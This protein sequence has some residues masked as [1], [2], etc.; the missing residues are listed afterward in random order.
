[1]SYSITN[2]N[3]MN[4][5]TS[6]LLFFLFMIFLASCRKDQAQPL[7]NLIIFLADDLGYNDISCYREATPDQPE[8]APTSMTPNI[9]QLAEEGM[10]FTGFYAGA[11]VCSPSRSALITGR[12]A[13][14]V[15]IYN[16]IPANCPMHL[17]DEEI[18]IAEM[19]KQ[20]G[21]RT[22]HFGKW[23]LTSPGMGQPLPRDQG[24][25]YSFFTY[26][27]A[28]PSH[29]DPVNFHRNGR[30]VGPLEGYACQL[31][32]DE[33]LGWLDS[34]RTG[35]K[36][37]FMNV[38]FNEPH[39]KLAAP[40][41]LTARHDYNQE[42]YGTIENM[43]LAIGR[44]MTFLK[45][46]GLDKNTILIFTSDNGSQ[47][48][49][50]NYPFRGS[51]AFNYEGG[52]RVPFVIKWA[53]EIPAGEVSGVTGSLTDVFPS[54]ASITG[55]ALPGDREFDGIDLSP[56]FR[57]EVDDYQREDPVF[58]YR[59]F[60]DP[61]CMLR[62][63]NWSLL[64]YDKLIPYSLNLNT[65]DLAKIKPEPGEP[66][67]SE[68]GFKENHMEIILEQEPRIFELYNLE[69]DPEQKNNLAGQYP[70]RV[71]EMKAR[72]L[73]LRKEMIEE[74]GDWYD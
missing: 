10:R 39:V 73:E 22:G 66:Q 41:E 46:N 3:I 51:K 23:H 16:W 52:V 20:K 74:G 7:P 50:S 69:T 21:Y 72:M 61:I 35:D 53:G 70:D 59:Y 2:L 36:P 43:D 27:N 44:V 65:V 58:F 9:D 47:V 28:Q 30:E 29:K 1:M 56:V 14:R 32:A 63:G 24:F 31:V 55:L 12:N 25:D 67:W 18:T 17:R 13:T 71:E 6:L 40:E 8:M 68:W 37:F 34:I 42:Y 48:R 26:N 62:E 60:H 57:G 33:A 19:V 11:A 15:G 5:T 49:H 4:K 64:G 38:W 54:V 45:D